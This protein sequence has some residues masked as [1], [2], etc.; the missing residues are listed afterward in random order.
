[1][2]APP[3]EMRRR[4]GFAVMV[5][6]WSGPGSFMAFSLWSACCDR[7]IRHKRLCND[8]IRNIVRDGVTQKGVRAKFGTSPRRYSCDSKRRIGEILDADGGQR[9]RFDVQ[10]SDR[11]CR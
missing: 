5:I 1:M 7:A 2:T 3:A 4:F 6:G 11:R 10:G 9:S 8:R